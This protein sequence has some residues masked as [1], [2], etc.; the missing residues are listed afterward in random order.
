MDVICSTIRDELKNG[1]VGDGNA[2]R[3]ESGKKR[4]CYDTWF[5]KERLNMGESLF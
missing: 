2:R 5:E 3:C 1:A 4:M